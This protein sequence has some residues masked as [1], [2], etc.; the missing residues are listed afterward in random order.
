LRPP[1]IIEHPTQDKEA[2]DVDNS[3]GPFD[4]LEA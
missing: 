2:M 1:P 4:G 3:G